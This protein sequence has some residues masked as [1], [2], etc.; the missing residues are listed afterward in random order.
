MELAV[1]LIVD[2]IRSQ[3]KYVGTRRGVFIQKTL[4]VSGKRY[5]IKQTGM[6]VLPL[7]NRPQ[8]QGQAKNVSR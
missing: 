7:S 6:S 5:I 4:Y 1:L 8:K 2:K 3:Q